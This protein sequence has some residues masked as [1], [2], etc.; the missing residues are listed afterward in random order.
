MVSSV[1]PSSLRNAT[2]ERSTSMLAVSIVDPFYFFYLVLFLQCLRAVK[3]VLDRSR[4]GIRTWR[5]RRIG[6]HAFIEPLT[7]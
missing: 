1:L 7:A 6:V 4:L 5:L 3:S 2:I